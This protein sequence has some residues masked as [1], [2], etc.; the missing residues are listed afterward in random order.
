MSDPKLST[1]NPSLL[2][3]VVKVGELGGDEKSIN[4]GRLPLLIGLFL[5]GGCIKCDW[6]S[7]F[8][9][10]V[11]DLLVFLLIRLD[12]MVGFLLK[13]AGLCGRSG[14]GTGAR[15]NLGGG[16]LGGG[17]FFWTGLALAKGSLAKRSSCQEVTGGLLAPPGG[18][19]AALMGYFMSICF[20]DSIY[21]S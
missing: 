16:G 9:G 12:R 19:G 18:G 1:L 7:L 5:V 11:A 20:L 8:A 10:S 13:W 6:N 14:L 15:L 21:F 2:D 17:F 3:R 4:E